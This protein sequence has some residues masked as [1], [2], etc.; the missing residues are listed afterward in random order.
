MT[1]PSWLYNG[2]SADDIRSMPA[3]TLED[4]LPY[5]RYMQIPSYLGRLIVH[6]V[7][8]TNCMVE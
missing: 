4:A 7:Q 6:K 5:I 1:I 3:D 8:S 2:L